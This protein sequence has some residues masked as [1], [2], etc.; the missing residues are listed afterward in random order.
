M[1]LC[2][3]KTREYVITE[4]KHHVSFREMRHDCSPRNKKLFI[5]PTTTNNHGDNTSTEQ[6]N[7]LLPMP[8]TY[9]PHSTHNLQTRIINPTKQQAY[10]KPLRYQTHAQAPQSNQLTIKSHSTCTKTSNPN[11]APT[12]SPS[13][14]KPHQSPPSQSEPR[15]PRPQP[16]KP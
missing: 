5:H 3:S 6:H 13:S 4:S 15:R 16:P 7:V 14:P 8:K 9:R 2:A 12:S 11:R 1:Y 10:R